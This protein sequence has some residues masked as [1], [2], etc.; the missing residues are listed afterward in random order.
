LGQE[1]GLREGP[2][3]KELGRAKAEAVETLV[4]VTRQRP[5]LRLNAKENIQDRLTQVI[6]VLRR[7]GC[8]REAAKRLERTLATYPE[9]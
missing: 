4:Q 2:P 8:D 5:G 6:A 1:T 3:S 9:P 7:G